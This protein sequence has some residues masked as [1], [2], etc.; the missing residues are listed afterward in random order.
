M[1]IKGLKKSDRH[2]VEDLLTHLK[3]DK[4]I[5]GALQ[6]GSSVT[7]DSYN[8]IDIALISSDVIPAKQK[9]KI[10]LSLPDS[11]DLKFI[12]DL[13]LYVAKEAIKGE[14]LFNRD[15]ALIFDLF[16]SI[17]QQWEDF[18]PQFELYLDVVANGL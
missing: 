15:Q 18:K 2:N 8:D 6:Y 17:F 4:R 16:V 11:I 9:L 10:L 7:A 13:P 12:E 3:E 5:I 14:L 1:G